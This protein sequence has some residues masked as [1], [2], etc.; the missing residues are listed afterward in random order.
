MM[1]SMIAGL[2]L[3]A[4]VACYPYYSSSMAFDVM[5]VEPAPPPMRVEVV[6]APPGMS[7]EWV[8]GY[9]SWNRTAYYW[10]PGHWER[11]P[12]YHAHWAPGRWRHERRGWYWVQGYWR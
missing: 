1:R 8:Q 3:A 6:S 4:S 12:R 9:W 10:V 5:Y 2:V 7:F 11:P